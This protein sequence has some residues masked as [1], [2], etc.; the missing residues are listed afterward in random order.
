MS[1]QATEKLDTALRRF[2]SIGGNMKFGDE[3]N[4][5][6]IIK[7][8]LDN[9]EKHLLNKK[10]I[11]VYYNDDTNNYEYLETMFTKGQFKH[12]CGISDDEKDIEI[13]SRAGITKQVISAKDFYK[14]CKKKVLSEKHIIVKR[15][16]TTIQKMNI[17]N[18]L[19]KLTTS[20]TLYCNIGRVKKR[21][22]L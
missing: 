13:Y 20:E 3:K 8:G 9:Y 6:H 1:W 15:D 12:L 11:F 22:K 17:L 7:S 2:Y 14:L 18:N 5:M 10:F 4:L 16:G 19:Y 21:F